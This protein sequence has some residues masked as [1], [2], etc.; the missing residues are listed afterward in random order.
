MRTK[1]AG[2]RNHTIA[3]DQGI[4]VIEEDNSSDQ[5][6]YVIE[7]EPEPEPEET[8]SLDDYLGSPFC[9]G[10]GK[11]CSLL[12]PRCGRGQDQASQATAEYYETYGEEYV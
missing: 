2:R 1:T 7:I 9:S 6:G 8:V 10:C 11:H 12:S 4:S 3:G 5:D